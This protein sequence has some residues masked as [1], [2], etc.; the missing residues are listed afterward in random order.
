MTLNFHGD[1]GNLVSTSNYPLKSSRYGKGLQLTLT[2]N[3]RIML[4]DVCVSSSFMVHSPFEIPG[5]FETID[6]IEFDYGYDLEVLITPEIIET[7]ADLINYKP[8]ERGCYF[9]GEK[10]LEFFKIYTRKNCESECIANELRNNPKVNCTPYFMARTDSMDYCDYQKEIWL[11]VMTFSAIKA[12]LG[13]KSKC[14]CL[15]E[16]DSI[17][18]KFEIFATERVNSNRSAN[19]PEDFTESS[20]R[21][22]LKDVDI[23]PLRRYQSFTFSE[24]LAQSGGML[25]LFAGVSVLSI[26]E[27]IYF[28]SLRW[29]VNL[30]RWILRKTKRSSLEVGGR[31]GWVD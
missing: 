2:R 25:G 1:R 3:Q 29:M 14:G 17:K 24:F 18:Y 27:L 16:C 6:L 20:F 31:Q 22:R 11:S 10:K 9:E 23:V 30:W 5:N 28:L 12:T 19:D 4:Q 21:F 7:D 15:D 26:I 13:S 8:E